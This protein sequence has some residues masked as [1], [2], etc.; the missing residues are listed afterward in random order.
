MSRLDASQVEAGGE[1]VQ[2]DEK[3][4]RDSDLG[5]N[6]T[7]SGDVIPEPMPPLTEER[8]YEL[9]SGKPGTGSLARS[10]TRR[11]AGGFAIS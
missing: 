3:A 10:F 7:T 8:R 5:V 2:V 4:I 11:F 9:P 6:P 1:M